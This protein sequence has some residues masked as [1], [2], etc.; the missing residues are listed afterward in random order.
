MIEQNE[1][2]LASRKMTRKVTDE[3]TGEVTEKE[4][5]SYT[6]WVSGDKDG[7]P[8]VDHSMDNFF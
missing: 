2:N 4:F 8:F 5:I 1:C 3:E 6:L 7:T